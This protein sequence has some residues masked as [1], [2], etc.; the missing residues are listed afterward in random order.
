MYALS[1][2]KEITPTAA[3]RAFGFNSTEPPSGGSQGT[4][5][6]L[7]KVSPGGASTQ[8]TTMLLSA[9]ECTMRASSQRWEAAELGA[10]ATLRESSAP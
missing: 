6:T 9:P 7:S 8:R 3:L 5:D 1:T 10:A 4:G 2:P